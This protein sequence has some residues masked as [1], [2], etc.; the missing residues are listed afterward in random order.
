MVPF[1][2]V[3]LTGFVSQRRTNHYLALNDMNELVMLLATLSVYW[4][5][6]ASPIFPPRTHSAILDSPPH[7][8]S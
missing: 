8:L 5:T 2:F 4:L 3:E 1:S 7:P 6:S